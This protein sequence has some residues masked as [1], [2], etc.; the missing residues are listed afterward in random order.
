MAAPSSTEMICEKFNITRLTP[1]QISSV[2]ALNDG[3]DLFVGTRTGS[4]KSLTY[5][6]IPVLF[7]AASVLIISP[8]VSIMSEQCK[9]L[10]EHGFKSTYIG[11]DSSENENIENGFFDFVFASPEQLLGNVKWRDVLKSTQYKEKLKAI[12]IDE[13]H[14][15]IHW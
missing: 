15:V 13:A 9:K 8:L 11:R 7:P 1:H 2:K 6:C 14:T 5:E 3:K 4:G 10:T 12:V